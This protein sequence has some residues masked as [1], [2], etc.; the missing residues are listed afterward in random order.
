MCE[1]E[2]ELKHSY[3]AD[4]LALANALAEHGSLRQGNL[5]KAARGYHLAQGNVVHERRQLRVLKLAAKFQS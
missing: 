1:I 4:L 3:T 2:L 5:S